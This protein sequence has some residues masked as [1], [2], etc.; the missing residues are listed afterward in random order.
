MTNSL[1]AKA[2]AYLLF[3]LYT[4]ALSLATVAT[5]FALTSALVWLLNKLNR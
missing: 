1:L 4:G 2:I 5:F 3:F